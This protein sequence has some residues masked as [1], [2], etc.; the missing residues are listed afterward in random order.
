MSALWLI[1]AFIAG[2]AVGAAFMAF[3][4]VAIVMKIQDT[5]AR[6]YDYEPHRP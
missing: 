2:V 6:G 1:P 4:L 3:A 5:R